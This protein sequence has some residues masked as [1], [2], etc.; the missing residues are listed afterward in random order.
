MEHTTLH[1]GVSMLMVG[2][3]VFQIADGS[4]TQT[5]AWRSSPSLNLTNLA[6]G[7]LL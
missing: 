7:G 6:G 1:N 3:G 4:V 2:F 5:V